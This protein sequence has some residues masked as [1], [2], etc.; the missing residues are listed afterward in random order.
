M[1]RL[2]SVLWLC[3]IALLLS[4]GPSLAWRNGSAGQGF[5]GGKSQIQSSD[6][7]LGGDYPFINLLKLGSSWIATGAT[8]QVNGSQLDSNGYPIVLPSGASNVV[9]T[10]FGPTQAS[11]PG[12]YVLAW[13]G[14][15]TVVCTCSDTLVSGSK[16][17]SGGSGRYVFSTT[18][19]QF[20]V[21]IAVIGSP[22]I[23]NMRLLFAAD[24][25]A[26]N[27][28]QI[29]SDKFIST[30]RAG[31]YGVFRFMDLQDE[32]FGNTTTWTTRKPVGYVYYAGGEFR[33][34]MYTTVSTTG[35]TSILAA[36]GSGNPVDKQTVQFQSQ[37]T[38]KNPS[39]V[40]P[41]YPTNPTW[42][43]FTAHGLN[44]GD[45][46]AWPQ[47]GPNGAAYTQPAGFSKAS[48]SSQTV[49]CVHDVVDA[50][51]ITLSTC[52]GSVITMTS[53]GSSGGVNMVLSPVTQFQMNGSAAVINVGDERGNFPMQW[54]FNSELLVNQNVTLVYDAGLNLWLKFGTVG[55]SNTR[56]YLDSGWPPEL[57]V[58]L[59]ALIGAHPYVN[60]PYL[61]A[62]N[63]TAA[64]KLLGGTDWASSFASYVKNNGPAWMIPRF[65][66]VNEAPWNSGFF[67]SGYITT[68]A[69]NVYGWNANNLYG[70]QV[71]TMGQDVNTAYGSPTN[72]GTKYQIL[73]GIQTHAGGAASS[74]DDKMNTPSYVTAAGS[75][76]VAGHNWI[77]HIDIDQYITPCSFGAN[78]EWI[79]AWDYVKNGTT[80]N[81]NSYVDT[82]N[83]VG[84]T[85]SNLDFM[86][87]LYQKWATYAASFTNNTG[88][89]IKGTGYEGSYNVLT[90]GVAAKW[91]VVTSTISGLASA[92]NPC[93]LTMNPSSVASVANS[94]NPA[95]AGM[96]VVVS[97][98]G[99][100]LG[101]LLN[102]STYTIQ[103][104]VSGNSVPINA[105][106][107]GQSFTSNGT[108]TWQLDG[109]ATG[110]ST[111]V[112]NTFRMDSKRLATNLAG[113]T[114]GNVIQSN[115]ANFI[116]AGVGA[117][118]VFEFP[119]QFTLAGSSASPLYTG[120]L[121]TNPSI[122][123]MYDRDIY[124]SPTPP[125]QSGIAAF[126]A[127]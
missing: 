43:T 94:G 56:G 121:G 63:G 88:Q 53:A 96:Q 125:A 42:I 126:N 122:W 82:L 48:P 26:Y 44:V 110:S 65:E 68:K 19:N 16:T 108:A 69:A 91:T 104:G 107:T 116:A 92:A 57:F 33:S 70:K 27:A 50:N 73:M 38:V 67:G 35:V 1:K 59:S 76:T 62:D 6:I 60:L 102:G 41:G 71:S 2:S 105:D 86:N 123:G 103:S 37:S 47:T 75:A 34:S 66:G 115:Y 23:T 85:G 99:G 58:T 81:L 10:V 95:V 46:V 9:T 77:T 18:G 72:D 84:C 89:K 7:G 55:T 49:Y 74:Q 78:Q 12:N 100:A 80:A 52:G 51:T 30:L 39:V 54:G 24:E 11:R 114:Y 61:A 28:G 113:W 21:G 106:C 25:A 117:G 40:T 79:W 64:N 5:N 93:V 127:H 13:D 101:T 98:V 83:Q 119:S 15:G 118:T 17:S 112:L 32:N 29:F 14:N 120:N 124:Q 111:Y 87:S 90:S 22:M 20:T 3:V 109:T 31:G 8:L 4:C 36:F 97:G 45:T